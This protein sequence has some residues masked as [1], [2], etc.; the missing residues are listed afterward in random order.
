MKSSTTT[1]HWL[2]LTLL[3]S[4]GAHA[5]NGVHNSQKKTIGQKVDSLMKLMT[6]DEKVGQMNQYNGDWDATGPI[7][8]DGD[9]QEQIRQ[10]KVGSML[11]VTGVA[12][13][14]TLQEIAMQSRLKIPLLFGQD[15]IHGYRTIFPR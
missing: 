12:H 7:T 4:F 6:L 10:G 2:A 11:N 9:K 8:K 5:Q 15:V 3:L 1:S 14:R 13:T